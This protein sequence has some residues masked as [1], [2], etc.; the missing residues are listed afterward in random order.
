M[1]SFDFTIE[2]LQLGLIYKLYKQLKIN[3]RTE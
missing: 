2:R 1:M 3:Y